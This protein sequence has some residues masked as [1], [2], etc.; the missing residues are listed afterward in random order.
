MRYEKIKILCNDIIMTGSGNSHEAVV[1][2]DGELD[3]DKFV[4]IALKETIKILEAHNEQTG[5]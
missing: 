2:C 5:T 3:V 1:Y 4:K